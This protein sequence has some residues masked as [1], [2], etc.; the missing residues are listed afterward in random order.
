MAANSST[1]SAALQT[2][3]TP[4]AVPVYLPLRTGSLSKICIT[5]CWY[6]TTISQLPTDHFCLSEVPIVITHSVP[7]S[8]AEDFNTTFVLSSATNQTDSGKVWVGEYRIRKYIIVLCQ[9]PFAKT[10]YAQTYNYY[11]LTQWTPAVTE[12]V[13][14]VQYWSIAT[15]VHLYKVY[16]I[17]F[18]VLHTKLSIVM[19]QKWDS[20]LLSLVKTLQLMHWQIIPF[21]LEASSSSGHVDIV[22]RDC[23]RGTLR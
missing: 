8:N 17:L 21:Y 6:C 16:I 13:Y 1:G 9:A 22:V 18:I 5:Q 3:F 7:L 12:F 11:S 4:T 2:G 15:Y 23:W 14:S 20:V 19:L 10:Y